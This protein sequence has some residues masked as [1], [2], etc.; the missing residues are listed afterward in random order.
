MHITITLTVN[1]APR[2]VTVDPDR[3]LLSVL[4]DVL[5]LTGAKYG[6]G[7]GKCGACTVHLDGKPVQACSLSVQDAARGRITTIEGLAAADHLYALQVAFLEL[8]A[9]QC[10]YCTPGMILSAAAL[11]A[12]NSAPTMTEI[13]H[14]LND[15]L[16]RCGA[17]PRIVAA[18]QQAAHWLRTGATPVMP[19]LRDREPSSALAPETFEE[20]LLVA[21]PDPDVTA[22]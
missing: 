10:G 15:N 18:V 2:I 4:R 3:T 14:A 20:G 12:E 7:D 9:L 16:C 21:Y 17:H 6:C 11:L 1:D 19:L 13:V 8:D 22:A 5:G